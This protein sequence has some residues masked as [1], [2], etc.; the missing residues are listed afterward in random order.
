M[1]ILIG[2]WYRRRDEASV[3]KLHREEPGLSLWSTSDVFTEEYFDGSG[4]GVVY[5]YEYEVD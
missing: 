5:E 3:S 1:M 4:G 2:C